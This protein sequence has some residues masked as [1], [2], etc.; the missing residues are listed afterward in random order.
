[1]AFHP[2]LPELTDDVRPF[3]TGGERGELLISH[4][5][6]CDKWFHPPSPICPDCYSL[7]VA[8]APVSGRAT[9]AAFTINYQPWMPDIPVPYLVAIVELEEQPDVRL[10]TRLVE[11]EIDAARIGLAVEVVFDHIEDVWLPL[12]RPQTASIAR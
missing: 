7:N 8:P 11:C 10:M 1:M 3:W 5:N 12:F 2:P 6:D 9:V 4:C